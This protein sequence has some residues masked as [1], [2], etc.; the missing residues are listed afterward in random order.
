[1]TTGWRRCP[2]LRLDIDQ[3]RAR[4]IGVSSQTVRRTLQ[5]VLSGIPIAEFREGDE[6][7]GVVLREPPETRGC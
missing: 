1:M 3:D 4:A 2:S 7:I 5:A 6:T